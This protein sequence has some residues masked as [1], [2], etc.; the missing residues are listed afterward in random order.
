MKKRNKVILLSSLVGVMAMGIAG[1]G[2]TYAAYQ[3]SKALEQTIYSD[4]Y[5]KTAVF[6]NPKWGNG[7][8]QTWDKVDN[9]K[10][11]VF[12]VYAWSSSVNTRFSWIAAQT[13]RNA[14]HNYVVFHVSTQLYDKILFARV[15]PDE[16]ANLTT[17]EPPSG[18]IWNQTG[19]LNFTPASANLYNL[20]G[21][22]DGS[23]A[24]SLYTGS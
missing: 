12:Y 15:N 8:D 16:V 13:R 10:T 22:N 20:S 7:A 9:D 18:T 19:D 11:P 3:N 17:K 4:G 21:W 6:L 5:A 24:G 23:W 2:I 14:Q 1:I